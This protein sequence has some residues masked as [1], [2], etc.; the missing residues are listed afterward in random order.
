MK[1]T[2]LTAYQAVFNRFQVNSVIGIYS[3]GS[4][5]LILYILRCKQF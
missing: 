5:L 2:D 3:C 4:K 1:I